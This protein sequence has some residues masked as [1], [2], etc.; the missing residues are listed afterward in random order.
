MNENWYRGLEFRAAAVDQPNGFRQL[1][2]LENDLLDARFSPADI[3]CPLG[4]GGKLAG[5]QTGGPVAMFLHGR[6]REEERF[7]TEVQGRKLRP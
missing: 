5:G 7:S 1:V 2:T 4:L 3:L 6:L